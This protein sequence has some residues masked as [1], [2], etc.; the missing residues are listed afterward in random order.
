MDEGGCINQSCTAGQ[1]LPLFCFDDYTLPF[2][3]MEE[4]NVIRGT[5]AKER[6]RVQEMFLF[7]VLA[8][9]PFWRVR[10]DGKR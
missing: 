9:C 4:G 6:E 1:E 10:A 2:T 7:C 3:S 5:S 8:P